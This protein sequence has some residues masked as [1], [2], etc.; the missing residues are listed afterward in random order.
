[1]SVLISSFPVECLLLLYPFL[2]PVLLHS[3]GTSISS[4]KNTMKAQYGG[5][6]HF[7]ENVKLKGGKKSTFHAT[8]FRMSSATQFYVVSKPGM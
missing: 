3:G 7:K 1:M 4:G 6:K 8:L 2:S 5:R